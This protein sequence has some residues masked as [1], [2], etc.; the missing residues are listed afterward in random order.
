MPELPPFAT[1]ALR[2]LVIGGGLGAW[3]VTQRLIGS[4][5]AD[6]PGIDDHLHRLT[7]DANDW[8]HRNPRAANALL[9]GSSLGVDAITLFVLGYAILG[10]SSPRSGGCCAC[11]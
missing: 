9:I 4:R 7:R 10:P 8:L 1:I 6:E 3:F 11:S 5:P 2:R